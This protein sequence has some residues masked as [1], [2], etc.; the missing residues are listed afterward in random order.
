METTRS[1]LWIVIIGAAVVVGLYLLLT[2][3]PVLSPSPYASTT[4]TNTGNSGEVTTGTNENTGTTGGTTKYHTFTDSMHLFT[5]S[6]PYAF[7]LG[8]SVPG[9]T[10]SWTYNTIIVNNITVTGTLYASVLVPQ[11]YETKTNFADARFTVGASRKSEALSVCTT[12]EQGEVD[13]GTV[14]I[15]GVTFHKFLGENAGAGNFYDSTSYRAVHNGQCWAVEYVIHTLNI[16]NF[17][18]SAGV[19]AFDRAKIVAALEGLV[20]SV[21][22]F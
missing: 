7:S 1:W 2:N 19:V 10:A 5:F 13:K 9:E 17:P 6:Y 22:F 11:N 18:P 21:K 16:G 8:A 4:P 12:K 20:T 3:V 15:H 14:V